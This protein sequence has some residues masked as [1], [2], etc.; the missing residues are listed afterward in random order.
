MA[1]P[2]ILLPLRKTP[3]ATGHVNLLDEEIVIDLV[4]AEFESHHLLSLSLP[5]PRIPHSHTS[6]HVMCG[7]NMVYQSFLDEHGKTIFL[8]MDIDFVIILLEPF[9]LFYP[10]LRA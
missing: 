5:S 1:E 2:S 10:V 6:N 9:T 7:T 8:K 4:V 3:T